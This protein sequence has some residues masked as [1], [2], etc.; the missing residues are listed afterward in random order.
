MIGAV[1]VKTAVP[2]LGVWL[3]LLAA[4]AAGCGKS[5][6]SAG[7]DSGGG[8]GET[9]SLTGTV[10]LAEKPL[11]HGSVAFHLDSG[12][13]LKAVIKNDGSYEIHNP[14]AGRARIV[15]VSGPPPIGVAG[16]GANKEVKLEQIGIS[17]R[18]ADPATTDLVYE[19]T[20]GKQTYDVVLKP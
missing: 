14:P 9:S 15:V 12:R 11:T 6:T 4:S 7:G 3:A 13:V 8:K 5:G 18:Y 20:A 1:K 19:I 17:A 2:R 10:R 16:G